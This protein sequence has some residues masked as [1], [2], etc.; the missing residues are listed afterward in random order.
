M[1]PSTLDY[2]PRREF[3]TGL[4]VARYMEVLA[5]I[6]IASM[7]AGPIFFDTVRI[8]LSFLLLFWAASA[9][10]RHSA[11]ARNWVLGI[12]GLCLAVCLLMLIWAAAFGTEGMTV[13]LGGR[14]TTNPPLWQ[15]LLVSVPIIVIAGLPFVVLNSR[16]ARRQF[17]AVRVE[18]LAEQ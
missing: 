3:D 16:R 14:R 4:F 17:S 8:D 5:W 18:K 12:S 1:S 6:S 11:A 10:K 13:S 2:S 15:V 7:I 9:L